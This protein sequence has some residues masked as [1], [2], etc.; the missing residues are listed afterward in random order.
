MPSKRKRSPSR[1]GRLPSRWKK[2]RR[3]GGDRHRGGRGARRGDE[4]FHRGGRSAGRGRAEEAVSPS[5]R[6]KRPSRRRR[7]PSRWKREPVEVAK[8]SIERE[9]EPV[10][11]ERETRRRAAGGVDFTT[12]TGASTRSQRCA[13]GV[14][15]RRSGP[16]APGPPAHRSLHGASSSHRV[17]R[18]PLRPLRQ[19]PRNHRGAARDAPQRILCARAAPVSAGLGMQPGGP[20]EFGRRRALPGRARHDLRGEGLAALRRRPVREPALADDGEDLRL[21]GALHGARAS[22]GMRLL[23]RDGGEASTTTSHGRCSTRSR[24]HPWSW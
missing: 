12:L 16:S 1:R 19:S 4:E 7:T 9:E 17:H 21:R 10:E 14:F 2:R 6:K 5:R 23:T 18:H 3:G 24:A 20:D 11:I 8:R 13:R 22:R 15:Q